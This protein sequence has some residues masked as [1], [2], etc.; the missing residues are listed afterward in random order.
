MLKGWFYPIKFVNGRC[1]SITV[2]QWLAL[3][4]PEDKA[5]IKSYAGCDWSSLFV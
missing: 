4:W 2:T 1:Y 5:R 3:Y